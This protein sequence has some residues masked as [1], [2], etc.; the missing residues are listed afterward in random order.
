LGSVSKGIEKCYPQ[1]EKTFQTIQP[2]KVYGEVNQSIP[3]LK[4]KTSFCSL[5]GKT[6][7]KDAIYLFFVYYIQEL[8]VEEVTPSFTII[9]KLGIYLIVITTQYYS[10]YYKN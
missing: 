8:N 10:K 5:I 9:Y 3:K 2:E 1:S 4:I 6:Q 7:L